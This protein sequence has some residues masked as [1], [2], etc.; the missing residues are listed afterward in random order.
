VAIEQIRPDASRAVFWQLLARQ[1]TET[2]QAFF[3][4]GAFLLLFTIAAV[5]VLGAALPPLADY[6]NH[7]SR[8]YIIADHG[9][10]PFLAKYYQV[11]WSPLPNL[12]MDAIV[13]ILAWA[14]PVE[15][16]GKVFLLML[17]FLDA[18]GVLLLHRALWR[19]WSV[20]PCLGLLLVFNRIFLRG[21]VN[22]LFGLGVAFCVVAMWVA[23]TPR[24]PRLRLA[25]S[26]V[27][28]T[29]VYFCHI[30]ACA[31]LGLL[32]LCFE[33]GSAF[34]ELRSGRVAALPQRAGTLVLPFLPAALFF[35]AWRPVASGPVQFREMAEKLNQ[36]WTV[37]SNYD[38]VLDALTTVG[39]FG[40]FVA[41]RI[42]RQLQVA[43]MLGWG[44]CVFGIV[45]AILPVALLS[46]FGA[47]ERL[48]LAI[49]MLLV[50]GTAPAQLNRNFS[51]GLGAAFC[52]LFLGRFAVIE[53]VWRHAQEIYAEDAA[54]LTELPAG[55]KLGLGVPW[56]ILADTDIPQTHFPSLAVPI[57]QAFV[58][59]MFVFKAQQPLAF[60]PAWRGLASAAEPQEIY[61]A[62]VSGDATLR[63]KLTSTLPLFDNILFVNNVPFSVDSG[64]C[65]IAVR[66][67]ASFQLFKVNAPGGLCPVDA[68]RGAPIGITVMGDGII[69]SKAWP[70]QK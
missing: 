29:L 66:A 51:L 13:P 22:F 11:E 28:V 7:L 45:Y 1:R 67:T 55:A 62:F 47:D 26:T 17:L 48:P 32:L 33:G 23:L 20:W 65:L 44:I 40:L 39:F 16:A 59:S 27:L 4:W 30:E 69:R 60:A 43:P 18:A 19:R 6:P 58:P 9:G 63:A 3:V 70:V 46:G 49:S 8:M 35:A 5:P 31:I 56:E 68:G 57:R 50:A 25:A 24:H 34:A 12:A 10:S 54:I 14:M 41:L 21:F 52:M 15:R 38:V 37:F 42:R 53:R 61:A 36:L 64:L 2:E